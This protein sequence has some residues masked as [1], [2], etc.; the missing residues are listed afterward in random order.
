MQQQPQQPQQL[1]QQQ[2]QQQPQIYIGG[3]PKF[4]QVI[5]GMF[6]RQQI[7]PGN[8]SDGR[9]QVMVGPF[10]GI[11]SGEQY[12]SQTRITAQQFAPNY[13]SVMGARPQFLQ[14]V[15][16]PQPQITKSQSP[17]QGQQKR[18]ASNQGISGS[19]NNNGGNA[20]AAGGGGG[21]GGGGNPNVQQYD[22]YLSVEDSVSKVIKAIIGES[23]QENCL[24]EYERF[25]CYVS[26]TYNHC[27]SHKMR[28]LYDLIKDSNNPNYD[29][30]DYNDD[31]DNAANN[32]A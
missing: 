11:S 3:Q 16:N 4:Q 30:D 8:Y 25:D 24:L 10:I 29:D 6:P 15:Q 17:Q 21:G 14:P 9:K 23:S 1:Q 2:Q 27:E 19:I 32:N 7:Q 28:T 22:A 20:A 18:M 13:V 12:P 5:Q 31:D 26:L